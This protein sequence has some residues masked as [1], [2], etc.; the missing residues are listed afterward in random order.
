MGLKQ[1]LDSTTVEKL[2]LR[3]AVTIS[4]TATIRD[5]VVKMREAGL[6]CVIAVDENN[7]AVGMFTEGMLRHALNESVGILD[8]TLDRQMVARLPWVLPSDPIKMVLEAMEEHNFRFIAVL[9]ED[10][11]VLGLTGQKSLME[12]IAD[13]FPYEVLT[14]DPTGVAVSRQKEGA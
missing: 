2:N 3:P 1:D 13:S 5:C 14:Q 9:D 10:H 4:Q 8:D 12:F 6:G 7:K 11:R